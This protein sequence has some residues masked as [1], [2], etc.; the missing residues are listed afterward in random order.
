M[1][2]QVKEFNVSTDALDDVEEMRRRIAEDGYLFFRDLLDREPLRELCLQMLKVCQDG[3]WLKA[4]SALE[5]AVADVSQACTFPDT[6]FMV[7][8]HEVI[9]LE[10][11]NL[12]S[13][14]PAILD[15]MG[16]LLGEPAIPHGRLVGRMGFPVASPGGHKLTT[17]TH[18]DFIYVQ[19]AA[20]TYTCWI[21][22]ADC[23]RELGG[24]ALMAGSN[25]G[26]IRQDADN[27]DPEKLT[28]EWLSTDYRRGDLLVFHSGTVH[29]GLHNL[30]PDRLRMSVDFRYS[31]VS[32]PK[33]AK[34]FIPHG[35]QLSWEEVYAGWQ[36]TDIQYYW[37]KHD[38]NIV[39]LDRDYMANRDAKSFEL[40]RKGDETVRP[41]LIRI[42]NQEADPEKRKAAEEALRELDKL[43][44]KSS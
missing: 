36:S 28:G 1:D 8:Y 41:A 26:G 18:Q 23:P 30:T 20:E 2:V 43:A 10:A 33:V 27:I 42:A 44:E 5:D 19:G 24:L 9:K 34:E 3:G 22:L 17:M 6:E 25:K 38:L 21:S 16:S 11:F 14:M 31:G 12:L 39:P 37:K 40:A 4:G 15:L 35:D 29:K 32:T 7:V 13:H